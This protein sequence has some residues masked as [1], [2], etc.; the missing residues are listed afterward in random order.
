MKELSRIRGEG[1]TQDDRYITGRRSNQS[2][3][4]EI[5]RSQ[6]DSFENMKS[7]VLEEFALN[8]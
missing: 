6:R 8:L 4:E 1:R 5:R 2:S 3:L 7:N